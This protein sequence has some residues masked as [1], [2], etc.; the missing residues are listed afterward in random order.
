[1]DGCFNGEKKE[2]EAVVSLLYGLDKSFDERLAIKKREWQLKKQE[3][4]E[5]RKQEKLQ[6]QKVPSI[7]QSIS[8]GS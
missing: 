1:M 6:H 2:I 7:S 3:L 5:I 8:F 4:N